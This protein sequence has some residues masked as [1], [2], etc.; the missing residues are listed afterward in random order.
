MP[1]REEEQNKRDLFCSY[2][3]PRIQKRRKRNGS[4]EQ[5]NQN[6]KDLY[7]PYPALKDSKREKTKW[8]SEK[9]TK[10]Q[11][12][13]TISLCTKKTRQGAEIR[14]I[15]S[16]I[17]LTLR[18]G[19][20]RRNCNRS[21]LTEAERPQWLAINTNPALIVTRFSDLDRKRLKSAPKNP[22][23]LAFPSAR[24]RE[25]GFVERAQVSAS[26]VRMLL[27]GSWLLHR[28]PESTTPRA[29]FCDTSGAFLSPHTISTLYVDSHPQRRVYG[30][31]T[32]EALLESTH[33]LR[34]YISS[35]HS[36]EIPCTFR[37]IV[38]NF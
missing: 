14:S 36:K 26:E 28:R 9:K 17:L 19:S 5:T 3:A 6:K 29:P 38:G 4:F 24:T 34:S 35:P 15:F 13:F 21:S 16:P 31:S 12:L 20:R 2:L 25:G 11:P 10:R 8:L 7:R 22:P 33:P 23:R 18:E 1:L 37:S 27:R 30:K 32:W